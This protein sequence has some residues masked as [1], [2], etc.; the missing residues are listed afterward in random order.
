VTF[1]K[2]ADAAGDPRHHDWLAAR[3][4]QGFEQVTHDRFPRLWSYRYPEQLLIASTFEK[5]ADLL[6]GW[7]LERF[8]ALTADPPILE[9]VA[10]GE[11]LGARRPDGSIHA[12]TP[13]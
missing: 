3:L 6:A 9:R 4:D 1:H 12:R 13:A 5:Q 11:S 8:D 10:G 7:V 2:N